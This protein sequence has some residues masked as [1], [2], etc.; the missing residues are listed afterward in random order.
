MMSEPCREMLGRFPEL[1]QVFHVLC[2]M[3]DGE[4]AAEVLTFAARQEWMADLSRRFESVV[5]RFDNTMAFEPE[6]DGLADVLRQLYAA[7]R[8]RDA[9]LLAHQPAPADDSVRKLDEALRRKQPV[10]GPSRS[11]R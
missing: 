4:D 10:F 5:A 8:V 7:S 3:G 2:A 11:I 6:D 9:L 1:R